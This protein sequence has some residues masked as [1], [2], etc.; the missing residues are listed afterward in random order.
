MLDLAKLKKARE[1]AGLTQDQAAAAAGLSGRQAWNNIERG[2]VDVT[3]STLDRI[4]QAVGKK[5]KDLLK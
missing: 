5:A 1:D 4:A 2:R 3:L